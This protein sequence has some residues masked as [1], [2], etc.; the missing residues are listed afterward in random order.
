MRASGWVVMAAAMALAGCGSDT[1]TEP[2]SFFRA[3]DI[4]VGTG[5][6]AVA[7]DRITVH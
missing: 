5:N 2:S 3:E 6:P 1:P 4:V 7:G